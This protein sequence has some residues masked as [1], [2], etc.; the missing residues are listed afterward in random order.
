MRKRL[1]L[2]MVLAGTAAAS[3][4][5]MPL[6]YDMLN[7]ETG[8]F[9]YWDDSYNG[10]GNTTQSLSPLS[11]G[12]GDLTDGI[13]A[14]TNWDITPSPYVGWW[15]VEP[16]ITFHFNPG[17]II[18]TIVIHADDSNGRGGVSTPGSVRVQAGAFDAVYA[19]PDGA[20]GDPITFSISDLALA[21]DT[22][23]LTVYDG[24]HP[25]VFLSEVEFYGVPAP[26]TAGLLVI[27][28]VLGRCRRRWNS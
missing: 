9:T 11:G 2:T 15:T 10:T 21:S 25:W 8:S 18:D 12:L 26:G 24:T 27:G 7:G 6:S 3:G 28:S 22:I 23:T 14:T 4:Q 1:L 20:S 19:I 16:A 13:I 5:V 17:T